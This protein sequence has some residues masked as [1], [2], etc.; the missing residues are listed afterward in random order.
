MLLAFLVSGIS[1][2]K[3][4]NKIYFE[5][6][7]L[8]VLSKIWLFFIHA[9]GY[10]ISPLFPFSLDKKGKGQIRHLEGFN[11][12]RGLNSQLEVFYTF[13]LLHFSQGKWLR[14]KKWYN[15]K[16]ARHLK[17][18]YSSQGIRQRELT[19][20]DRILKLQDSY[21]TRIQKSDPPC[22]TRIKNKLELE[23]DVNKIWQNQKPEVCWPFIVFDALIEN[24]CS[25][26]FKFEIVLMSAFQILPFIIDI[27]D[28]IKNVFP[29][30]YSLK[31]GV[32]NSFALLKAFIYLG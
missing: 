31:Y 25:P 23:L 19:L 20:A 8:N 10:F 27:C 32:S 6:T 28:G 26:C 4:W 29:K 18:F 9:C 16:T 3:N 11:S 12:F 13:L 5:F 7:P 30:K 17:L 2:V 24:L 14:E 1:K 15:F 22:L 21:E